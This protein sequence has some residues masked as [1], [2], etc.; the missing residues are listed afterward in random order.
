MSLIHL[1]S[2]ITLLLLLFLFLFFLLPLLLLLLLFF[3]T[4]ACALAYPL[5]CSTLTLLLR[6]YSFVR[7]LQFRSAFSNTHQ[8]GASSLEPPVD[9]SPMEP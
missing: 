4:L 8:A 1:V 6:L 5:L 2:I 7:L 3:S 9:A